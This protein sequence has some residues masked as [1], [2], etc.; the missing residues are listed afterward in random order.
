MHSLGF[1]GNG[2]SGAI[3][4]P[5]EAFL[6]AFEIEINYRRDVERQHLRN[7]ESAN[8]GEA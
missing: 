1:R 7:D 5:S 3:A 4:L 6:E 8:Y 2:R